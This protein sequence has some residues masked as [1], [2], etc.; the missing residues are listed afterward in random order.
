MN[1]LLRLSVVEHRLPKR[2]VAECPYPG[3]IP[4]FP[5]VKLA[6]IYFVTTSAML[7]S[8]ITVV[9]RNFQL[10]SLGLPFYF[11]E[12]SCLSSARHVSC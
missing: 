7:E 3:S 4:S 2:N 12:Y 11:A 8:F 5:F 6:K 9:M 1:Y 10:N